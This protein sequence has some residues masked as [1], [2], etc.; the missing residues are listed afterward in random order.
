M[1]IINT[2]A[3]LGE[4]ETENRNNFTKLANM[5]NTRKLTSMNDTDKEATKQLERAYHYLRKAQ[6]IIS[7]IK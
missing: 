4:I 1:V 3:I 6:D 2:N 7:D 5:I